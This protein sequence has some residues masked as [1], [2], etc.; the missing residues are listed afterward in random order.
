MVALPWEKVRDGEGQPV[1]SGFYTHLL[2]NP[3]TALGP[4]L[5]LMPF[6]VVSE[7][8]LLSGSSFRELTLIVGGGVGLGDE[9]GRQ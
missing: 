4:A 5:C 8:P 9:E 7:P 3:G 2:I 6:P 1:P